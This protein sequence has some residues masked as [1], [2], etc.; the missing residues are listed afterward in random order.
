MRTCGELTR[1]PA[2]SSCP[3]AIPRCPRRGSADPSEACCSCLLPQMGTWVRGL[4]SHA[5]AAAES[6]QKTVRPEDGPSPVHIMVARLASCNRRSSAAQH[7]RQGS[8]RITAAELHTCGLTAVR[9]TQHLTAAS[10]RR[11]REPCQSRT[12]SVQDAAQINR[13]NPLQQLSRKS[14]S[15]CESNSTRYGDRRM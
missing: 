10:R 14:G 15:S 13:R 2:V 7:T 9:L 4:R 12:L 11:R 5:V 6:K 3:L 8:P 1:Q